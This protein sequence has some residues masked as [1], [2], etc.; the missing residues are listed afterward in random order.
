MKKQEKLK[1]LSPLL[2]HDAST[3]KYMLRNAIETFET[4]KQNSG[5]VTAISDLFC[6]FNIV[7]ICILLPCSVFVKCCYCDYWNVRCHLRFPSTEIKLVFEALISPEIAVT[8]PATT[9][10]REVIVEDSSS[11]DSVVTD[12]DTNRQE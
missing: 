10:C 5:T 8:L 7:D 6:S 11:R 12:E 9:E 1:W 2:S 4:D 3:Q